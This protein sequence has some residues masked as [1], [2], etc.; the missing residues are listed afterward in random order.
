MPAVST[1]SERQSSRPA[2]ARSAAAGGGSFRFF[3]SQSWTALPRQG[4]KAPPL[5]RAH[6]SASRTTSAV[7]SETEAGRPYAPRFARPTSE[8][9]RKRV[10]RAST[11]RSSSTARPSAAWARPSCVCTTASSATVP[12]TGTLRRTRRAPRHQAPGSAATA[13]APTPS[14]TKRRRSIAPFLLAMPHAPAFV[15]VGF[16]PFVRIPQRAPR[17]AAG[18]APS[19]P[20]SRALASQH[21]EEREEQGQRHCGDQRPT[22]GRSPRRM[23][24]GAVGL[25]S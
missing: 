16:L 25:M 7:S 8:S 18:P 11:R 1:S 19:S 20:A 13:N 14:A 22:H 2:R 15:P 21:A 5:P 3:T 6:P 23:G 4:S 24:R 12:M 9:P 17:A 10:M